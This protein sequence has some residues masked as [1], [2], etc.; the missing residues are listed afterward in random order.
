MTTHPIHKTL[1]HIQYNFF[2]IFIIINYVSYIALAVGIQIVS[3]HYLDY[4]DYFVKIYIGLFLFV[5]FNPFNKIVFNDLDRRIAF[6]AGIFLLMTTFINTLVQKYTK[7]ALSA[8]D[9]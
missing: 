4:L 6:S 7:L 8:I 3:P 5:R 1:Y 9:L 2:T